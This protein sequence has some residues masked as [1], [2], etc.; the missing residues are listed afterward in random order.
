MKAVILNEVDSP[1]LIKEVELTPIKPGQVLVKV[2]TSG[3]CGAQLHEIRG[4]KGN[5]KFMPHLLGHEGC[6]IVKEIGPGAF[7]YCCSLVSVTGMKSITTFEKKLFRGC[8][9]LKTITIPDSVKKIKEGSFYNCESL[10]SVTIPDS[11]TKIEAHAFKGCTS[12]T[13]V[14]IPYSLWD[15]GFAAFPYRTKIIRRNQRNHSYSDSGSDS[16]SDSD[17]D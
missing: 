15:Y 17:S 14:I 6:G 5:A 4:H 13:S 7:E 9:S 11:V 16:G 1:L 8:R 12:L 3:L 10:T 2:L